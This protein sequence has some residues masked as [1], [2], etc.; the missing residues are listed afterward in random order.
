MSLRRVNGLESSILK[1]NKSLISGDLALAAR[2]FESKSG[3]TMEVYTTDPGIQIY[4][5]NFWGNQIKGKDDQII[6]RSSHDV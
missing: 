1:E 6:F 4:S 2:V 3:R 5:G